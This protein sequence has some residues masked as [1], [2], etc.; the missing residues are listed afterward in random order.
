MALAATL[1]TVAVFDR[2]CVRIQ[3]AFPVTRC[4]AQTKRGCHTMASAVVIVSGKHRVSVRRVKPPANSSSM[5]A[6]SRWI[7]QAEIRAI[8]RAARKGQS[9]L[10]KRAALMRGQGSRVDQFRM[11]GR[12]VAQNRSRV[13]VGRKQ[14]QGFMSPKRAV[15]RFKMTTT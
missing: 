6:M 15:I 13:A 8:H 14:R 12:P 11:Q 10:G 4:R 1:N 9:S 2:L 3:L 7:F 5:L